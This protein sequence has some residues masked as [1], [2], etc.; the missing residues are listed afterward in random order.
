MGRAS[1]GDAGFVALEGELV[2]AEAD[3]AVQTLTQCAQHGVSDARQLGGD[4]VRDRENF[5][6]EKQCRRG[7]RRLA[8]AR[9]STFGT[10][11]SPTRAGFGGRLAA[12]R[13]LGTP[14][15]A[16]KDSGRVAGAMVDYAAR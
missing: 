3:G 5:L 1:L 8:R 7:A 9:R 4:V 10:A 14:W 12:G 15:A 6:Q 2:A 11:A 16:E 13:R